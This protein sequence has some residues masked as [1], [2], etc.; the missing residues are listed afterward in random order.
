MPAM[1]FLKYLAA[2]LVSKK[3]KLNQ[4]EFLVGWT[5]CPPGPFKQPILNY[6]IH[7][8]KRNQARTLRVILLIYSKFFRNVNLV[9]RRIR[10]LLLTILTLLLIALPSQAADRIYLSY[11]LL[12]RS[13]P[14]EQLETFAETGKSAGTLRSILQ[15]FSA[16]QQTEIQKLLQTQYAV[17]PVMFDRF[18]YTSSG[19]KL[20]QEVGQIIQSEARQNGFKGIR[21]AVTLAADDPGGLSILG[22]L[23][24]FPTDMRIDLRRVLNLVQRISTILKDTKTI[25]ADLN[26]QTAAI[27]AQEPHIDFNQLSDPRQAGLVAYQKRVIDLYDAKRDR[28]FAADL[29][30]PQTSE[31]PIPLIV[32]SNGLGAGR[33]RFDEIAP[34]LV[35]HGFAVAVPDHPGSDR[36][37]LRDFYA[38]LHR[39]NFEATEYIERPRDIQFLLDELER[40]NPTEFGDRL[41]TRQVGIFGYSFGG[42][43][44]L[45]LAGATIDF[46]QLETDCQTQMGLVNISLLYQ[47]RALELPRD[48]VNLKDDRIK[49]AYLFVPFSKSL[50]GQMANVEIP[51]F[52]QVTDLDIL[53]PLAVEQIPAFTA[54]QASNKYLAVTEGLPHARVTY[55]ALSRITHDTTPWEQLKWIGQ[56]YQNALSLAFFQVYVAQS[57]AYRSYLRSA[58]ALAIGQ[59]PY[60]L[61]LISSFSLQNQSDPDT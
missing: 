25:V 49:A 13:I 10:F 34:H 58:Y 55:D 54:L 42:S 3:R 48:P 8:S 6:L 4:T 53:T 27:A 23:Q 18:A 21:S 12:G 39:E 61:S 28:R 29:Y 59:A 57:A 40:R 20:L 16:D 35:S 14:L 50:F 51:I 22:F 26:Q 31:A 60:R 47:C 17:D 46:D 11:G 41:N 37:Y 45:S 56:D 19:E 36:Q 52:W 9:N 32:G 33:D 44:A 5:S 2:R 7:N 1:S 38:G 15:R 43:T 24:K 30:L